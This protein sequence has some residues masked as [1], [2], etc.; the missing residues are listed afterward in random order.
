MQLVVRESVLISGSL[1]THEALRAFFEV[2]DE[3]G[4]AAPVWWSVSAGSG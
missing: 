4:H 2:A 1:S 3:Q